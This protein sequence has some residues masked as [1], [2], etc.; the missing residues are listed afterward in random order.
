M[1]ERRRIASVV[2]GAPSELAIVV[3]RGADAFGIAVLHAGECVAFLTP[4]QAE[5][6]ADRLRT[7]AKLARRPGKLLEDAA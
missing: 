7:M 4:A 5:A 1:T 2:A 3:A 6:D